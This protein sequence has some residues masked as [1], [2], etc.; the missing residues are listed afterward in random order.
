MGIQAREPKKKIIDWITVEKK[1]RVKSSDHKEEAKREG[2]ESCIRQ[3]PERRKPT[4]EGE[5]LIKSP[6][7]SYQSA[8]LPGRQRLQ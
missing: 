2:M 8:E 4:G 7:E 1:K 3:Q 5:G 6:K